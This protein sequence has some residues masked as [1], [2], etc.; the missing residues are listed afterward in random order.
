MYKENWSLRTWGGTSDVD[1]REKKCPFTGSK[2]TDRG[3]LQGGRNKV[4]LTST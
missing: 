1:W 3:N 4:A 2:K